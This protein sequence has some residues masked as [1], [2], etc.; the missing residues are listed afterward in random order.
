MKRNRSIC[1]GSFKY[2][3]D[4]SFKYK[5]Y[6]I[7]EVG[8]TDF[9]IKAKYDRQRIIR[10]SFQSVLQCVQT[11]TVIQKCSVDSKCRYINWGRELLLLSEL[12]TFE[13]LTFTIQV[14]IDWV[15]S[16]VRVQRFNPIPIR[17][18]EHNSFSWKIDEPLNGQ[19][20]RMRRGQ[21]CF[22]GG[23]HHLQFGLFPKGV[24][25][26][27]GAVRSQ[28]ELRVS[29][30]R[31]PVHFK[32][33]QYRWRLTLI[34]VDGVKFDLNGRSRIICGNGLFIRMPRL[35]P[36][37]R[38]SPLLILNAFLTVSE[39]REWDDDIVNIKCSDIFNDSV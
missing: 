20:R 34:A 13:S 6:P 23:S 16:T 9:M 2:N 17:M 37:L 14:S 12:K 33:I 25:D 30:S 35:K 28:S 29:L 18:N 27:N 21:Q 39:V 26:R 36:I 4:I 3:Q 19:L 5:I 7:G 15:Q 1:K 24:L 32:S 22:L 11:G 38:G 10:L 31:C 8:G